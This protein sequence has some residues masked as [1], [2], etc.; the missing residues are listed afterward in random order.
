[1]QTPGGSMGPQ[2]GE[3]S[4][5]ESWWRCSP[6]FCLLVL[7]QPSPSGCR[8]TTMQNPGSGMG[9][10]AGSIE[11]QAGSMGAQARSYDQQPPQAQGRGSG[12]GSGSNR[13]HHRMQGETSYTSQLWWTVMCTAMVGKGCWR[14]AVPLYC[15]TCCTALAGATCAGGGPCGGAC[16]ASH[17]CPTKAWHSS[18][19]T[20][21]H[22]V[23]RCRH[24]YSGRRFQAR[25]GGWPWSGTRQRP[26]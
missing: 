16:G 23:L 10:H 20:S 11:A 9:R 2:A 3:K 13:Q 8:N 21:V 19:C 4:Y 5:I 18:L 7:H 1:M 25:P 12:S 26:V 6:M 15:L 14:M 22:P 17:G 24:A